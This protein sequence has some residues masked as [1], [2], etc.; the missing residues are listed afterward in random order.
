M[1]VSPTPVREALI[2]LAEEEIVQFS[3]GRG[4]YSRPVKADEVKA[5]YEMAFMMAKYSIEKNKMAFEPAAL[6]HQLKPTSPV[7]AKFSDDQLDAATSYLEGLYERLAMIS[8]NLKL[9]RAMRQFNERTHH[10][11]RF[12]FLLETQF[13]TFVSEMKTLEDFLCEGDSGSALA[14]LVEQHHLK[15]EILQHVLQEFEF[16]SETSTAVLEDL[17]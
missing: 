13:G 8:G 5:D 6:P 10:V 7:L 12:G 11:R 4:Y 2:R 14:T 17:I 16:R 15:E 9:V 3:A 1:R